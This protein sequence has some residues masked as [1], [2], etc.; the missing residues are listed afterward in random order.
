MG[1][2]A[3]AAVRDIDEIGPTRGDGEAHLDWRKYH[4]AIGRIGI[5]ESGRA[6]VN[7]TVLRI[8]IWIACALQRG[9]HDLAVFDG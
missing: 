5:V 2:G 7:T 9:Q 6:C 1:T 3:K 4:R 8:I